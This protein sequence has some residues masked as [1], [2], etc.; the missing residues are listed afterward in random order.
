MFTSNRPRAALRRRLF[1][2]MF[3]YGA[4]VALMIACGA[5]YARYS[6]VAWLRGSL[7]GWNCRDVEFFIAELGLSL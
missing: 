4:P 1:R 5:L 6:D 7:A 3:R 2:P